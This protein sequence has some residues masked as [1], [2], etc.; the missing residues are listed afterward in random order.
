MPAK[1]E[2]YFDLR[3]VYYQAHRAAMEICVKIVPHLPESEEELIDILLTSAE[4]IPRLIVEGYAQKDNRSGLWVDRA[5]DLAN[6][7]V[8]GLELVKE[9][10]PQRVDARVCQKL[11]RIYKNAGGRIHRL[12][13]V[14][15]RL[16]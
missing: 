3:N 5:L 16:V 9:H 14:W 4:A 1:L 8:V 13:K 12:A 10:Y 11:I 15:N 6:E 7:M 2:K